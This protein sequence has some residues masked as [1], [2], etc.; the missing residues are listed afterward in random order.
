MFSANP[1]NL[2][3]FIN[4]YDDLMPSFCNGIKKDIAP[5]KTQYLMK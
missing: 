5:V 2:D 1:D 4:L 3:L